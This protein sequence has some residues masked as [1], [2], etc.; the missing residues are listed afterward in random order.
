MSALLRI[1][2]LTLLA[3]LAFTN[4]RSDTIEQQLVDLM[5]VLKNKRVAM[6]TNPTSV[7]GSMQPLFDRIIS[8][9][10]DNNVTFK[11]FFAPEHGLRGDR[12][13]GKGDDDY[14][15][16]I[17]GIQV[18]SLYGVRKAPT[19]A[20]LKD[21]DVLVYD[22][23][24]VGARYYTFMWTLTYTIE[25]CA[26]N[27][28]EVAVFDRPNPIGRN[29]EGCPLEFDIGLTGRLLPGQSFT[30]PQRY[31][32][33]VAEFVLYLRP[34]LPSFKLTII[35][36]MKLYRMQG[37]YW[38]P[39]SPNIPTLTTTYA[40]AGLGMIESTSVSE[41]RGTTKPFLITGNPSVNAS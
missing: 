28:V 32:L 39:S 12:Q 6:L 25:A 38:V 15:D 17:T 18:Y 22:I 31:G 4:D 34:Y 7:D 37:H 9:S 33:T 36:M 35:K 40:Y 19:N 20:Q 11:C 41:G 2:L 16:P 14:I 30:I 3:Q 13:D 1:L 21:V 23:Q 29:V 26:A 24:D 5:S 8:L 10:K 27:D